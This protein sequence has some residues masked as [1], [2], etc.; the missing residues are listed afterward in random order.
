MEVGVYK[1]ISNAAYHGGEGI[2]KSG[3]DLIARSPLH[4]WSAYIDPQREPREE[5][6]AMAL[7]TA[8]HSAVLEP[9][10]FA[11]DYVVV[12]TTAP[13]RPSR[14]Q[15]NAK[16]PSDDTM[17]AIVW[18]EEFDRMN[19]GR[20]IISAEDYKTCFSIQTNLLTHPAA[21]TLLVDGEPEL[22][23]FWRDAETGVLCKCRPDYMNYKANVIVDVKSTEDASPE[24][25]RRSIVKYGYHVQAAW[26]LDGFKA[27]TGTAPKAFVFAAFEK[28]RPYATAF[29]VA[30]ADMI[31]LGRI[32]YRERLNV[33][34]ECLKRNLWPGY[35]Q[36]VQ[37]ISLPAWVLK[38]ANDNEET[39]ISYV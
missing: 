10:A 24:G 12:P 31:E 19:A 1:G 14:T 7:G 2:S 30:D 20:T 33:F 39:E 11:T 15:L 29:Y 32:L 8:I 18:W 38:A 35:P 13:K 5:T 23:V 36:Q 26:Y 22:S 28:K 16:K 37:A 17:S 34:A 27:A 25:F 21:R 4:Y 6:P 3:L 9:G